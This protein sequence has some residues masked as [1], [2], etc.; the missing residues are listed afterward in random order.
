MDEDDLGQGAREVPEQPVAAL[1][2]LIALAER[3]EKPVD[4]EREVRRV[5]ILTDAEPVTNGGIGRYRDQFLT[6]L[7]EP[8]PRPAS[9]DHGDNGRDDCRNQQQRQYD[10][11]WRHRVHSGA[12]IGA[13][14]QRCKCNQRVPDVMPL[15]YHLLLLV[16]RSSSPKARLRT[17]KRRKIRH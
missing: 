17:R 2:L 5:F 1:D 11:D 9:A 4:S 3:I 7:P 12:N 6:E 14:G 13:R 15:I 16:A 10:Q 8:F